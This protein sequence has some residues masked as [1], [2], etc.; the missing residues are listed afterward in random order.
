MSAA[1]AAWTS[2]VERIA[3]DPHRSEPALRARVAL[4]VAAQEGLAGVA[5]EAREPE[6]EAAREE[7]GGIGRQRR[8]EEAGR[9]PVAADV[10][11]EVVGL[12]CRVAVAHDHR[13][14]AVRHRVPEDRQAQAREVAV[15]VTERRD[16]V[17]HA[18]V[19]AE[20]GD[21]EPRVRRQPLVHIGEEA[22]PLGG[23]E[24]IGRARLER[25]LGRWL[26]EL[27]VDELQQ[28]DDALADRV[29]DELEARA[30]DVLVPEDGAELAA[31][32]PG[33]AHDA[34]PE[35]EEGPRDDLLA[36][37][38]AGDEVGHMAA[39]AG[40]ARDRELPE[41]RVLRAEGVLVAE[42][43]GASEIPSH[44]AFLLSGSRAVA[45]SCGVASRV[46]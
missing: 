45:R 33:A 10:A 31:D 39:D 38:E 21:L 23:R 6:H 44:V 24:A 42:A 8:A 40:P 41:V 5:D 2:F 20:V 43:L 4:R 15:G 27:L 29:L 3:R 9:A 37:D 36:L 17:V 12:E 30:R 34:P 7:P 19:V 22:R 11:P 1:S 26:G 28:V 13:D 35:V 46:R 25:E 14:H 18:R 32:P 16:G